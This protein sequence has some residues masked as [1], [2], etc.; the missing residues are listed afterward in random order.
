[1][2]STVIQRTPYWT[3]LPLGVMQEV[4]THYATLANDIC[5][6]C[7]LLDIAATVLEYGRV[8]FD[9]YF[10]FPTENDVDWFLGMADVGPHPSGDGWLLHDLVTDPVFTVTIPRVDLMFVSSNIRRQALAVGLDWEN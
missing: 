8:E 6:A 1:M 5:L 2:D 3:E 7:R 9:V 10:A 4:A